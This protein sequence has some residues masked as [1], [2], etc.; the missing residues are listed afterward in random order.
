MRIGHIDILRG[1]CMVLIVWYHTNHPTILDYPFFNATLFFVS[2]MLLHPQSG[3]PFL[4]RKVKRLLISFIFFY[5]VYYL[6]LLLINFFKYHSISPD[7]AWSILDVFRWNVN[8]DGYIC[9]YPLWFIWALL[10]IQ[11]AAN[12]MVRWLKND[13]ALCLIAIVISI[14]GYRY[15]KHIPTPFMLG[16]STS[17]FVYFIAGYIIRKVNYVKRWKIGL[18]LSLWLFVVLHVWDC[19]IPIIGT[20]K[21]MVELIAISVIL[22]YLSIGL[23]H[24]SLMKPLV[25]F[26]VN[27]MIVFGVHDM[28]L[29]VLRMITQQTVGQM[30]VWLGFWNWIVVL[31]LMFPTIFVVNRYIP[32]VAGKKRPLVS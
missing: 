5:V 2:G 22:L 4:I 10:W 24:F 19:A 1:L 18:P 25:F 26:G 6:F 3:L 27:S 28:Y 7:I 12:Y 32:V 16:R 21:V 17:L 9:N 13:L 30:D 14:I 31:I 29:T 23:L 20:L 11:I 15:I 8:N